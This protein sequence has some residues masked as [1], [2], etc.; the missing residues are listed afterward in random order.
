M[1]KL[2]KKLNPDLVVG[3]GGYVSGPV[4][5]QAA[6]LGFKTAIHEQNAYPGVTTKMLAKNAVILPVCA[7]VNS[8]QENNFIIAQ[9][10]KVKNIGTSI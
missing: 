4:L 7:K 1:R 8:I 10:R 5:S 6:K 2:L 3:T 9:K